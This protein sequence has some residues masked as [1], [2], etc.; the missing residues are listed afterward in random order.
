MGSCRRFNTTICCFADVV[1]NPHIEVAAGA[2]RMADQ[3]PAS[4]GEYTTL[5][6]ELRSPQLAYLEI[7]SMRHD[8]SISLALA[9]VI[10]GMMA[11]DLPQDGAPKAVKVRK[12]MTISLRHLAFVDMLCLRLGLPRFDIIRRLIDEERSLD[13]S[14]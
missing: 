4:R 2:V 8:T 5:A 13:L 6:V 9:R 14:L 11:R 7:L 1:L 12:H 10:D 3:E